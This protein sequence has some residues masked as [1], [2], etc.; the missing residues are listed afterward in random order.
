MLALLVAAAAAALPALA[1]ASPAALLRRSV[2]PLSSDQ[3]ASFKPF[4]FFA[5]AGYCPA[6]ATATWSCGV[7]C[8]ALA[9]FEVTATGGDGGSTQFWFVGFYSPLN[10]V[11]VS[12]QGTNTSNIIA[13]GTDGDFFLVPLNATMFPTAPAGAMVHMGFR[14]AQEKA[15]A[16]VLAAVTSSLAAHPGAS[17]TFASHS[18]GAAIGLLDALFIRPLIPSSTPFKFV[19]YGLPRVGNPT[20]ADWVDSLLPDLTRVNNMQDPVPIIPGRFLGFGHP[21][22]EVHISSTSQWLACSGQDSEETG[23]INDTEPTIFNSDES[24]HDGPYDGIHVGGCDS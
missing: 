14:E 8:D 12:H 17:V 20:F 13:I 21:S 6:A 2:T 7:N 16:D 5:A 1:L 4:T 23:C 11:V 18:L 24:N 22:G 10:S 3:I 9:G 19:G 15:A